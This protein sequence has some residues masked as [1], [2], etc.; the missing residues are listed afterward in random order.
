MYQQIVNESDW[1]TFRSKLPEWQESY[2]EKL[3]NE[4][5][6]LLAGP[7]KVSDKFWALEKRIWQD[8][9]S[10]GVVAPMSRSNMYLNLLNL[11]AEEI[12]T[13]DDLDDF[14]DDL[15]N[16]MAFVTRNG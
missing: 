5:A 4:Y 15:R 10:V 7:G 2:M 1:K 9:K 11:L 3:N 16:K 13:L 8:K 14:S 12:I 6:M